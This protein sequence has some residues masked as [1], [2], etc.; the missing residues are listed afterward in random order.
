MKLDEREHNAMKSKSQDIT[1]Q[2]VPMEHDINLEKSLRLT[3]ADLRWSEKRYRQ[4][5]EDSKDGILIID[6]EQHVILEVNES[7]AQMLDYK[8]NQLLN[9]TILDICPDQLHEITAI[10][11]SVIN[12]NPV[13]NREL[14]CITKKDRTLQIRITASLVDYHARPAILL[15]MRDFTEFKELETRLIRSEKLLN[16]IV[17]NLPDII[18]RLDPQGKITFINDAVKRY[19][20]EPDQLL[21]KDIQELVHPDDRE[22]TARRIAERRTGDRHTKDLEVRLLVKDQAYIPFEVRSNSV[23]DG[24][25]V[26]LEV[27]GLYRDDQPNTEASFLGSQGVARDVTERKLALESIRES[28][29]RYRILSEATFE[30]IIHSN[31]GGVVDVNLALVDMLGYE[32]E[33]LLNKDAL[34]LIHPEDHEMVME[35]LSTENLDPYELRLIHKNGSVLDAE[36][37]PRSTKY[38]GQVVRLSAVRDITEQKR[39]AELERQ[40]AEKIAFLGKAAMEFV[41]VSTEDDIYS[42]IASK[43]RELAGEA[44][45][46]VATEFDISLHTYKVATIRGAENQLDK[47]RKLLGKDPLT[48]SGQLRN[49]PKVLEYGDGL[50]KVDGGIHEASNGVI[51]KR[52]AKG[53]EKLFQIT[54]IYLINFSAEDSIYGNLVILLR[55][56]TQ[57]VDTHLLEAFVRNASVALSRWQVQR[58]H[59]ES[60]ERYRLLVNNIPDVTWIS[61]W[62]GNTSFISP[63]VEQVY[64]FTPDE[65]ITTEQDLWFDRIHPDDLKSV[66]TALGDF[67]KGAERFDIE[68]RI[69][70]K[71]GSWIWIHD[72]AM[73]SYEAGGERYAYG[74]FS[75][76]TNRKQAEEERIRLQTAIEQSSEAIM[77]LDLENKAEY[78]NPA[79]ENMTGYHRDEV[80]GKYPYL[81]DSGLQEPEFYQHRNLSS[82][83]IWLKRSGKVRTGPA[84]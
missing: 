32:K 11:H 10:T 19:G 71:D 25:V 75:D 9:Q 52:A 20:Y 1:K 21:N 77:L 42:L 57:G 44:S 2:P 41:N 39:T 82:I 60:E 61:D 13:A 50:I 49:P 67:F 76:I 81:L 29:E 51:P 68:Y 43:I 37:R 4:I 62:K 7:L 30:G 18:Y 48:F 55:R 40:N 72:R 70:R 23:V 56:G 45:I 36:V 84:G 38:N 15:V 5:L 28:E 59:K 12:G 63:N 31:E 69:K 46:V 33:E 24:P 27:E 78:V 58:K 83:S 14:I 47:A 17:G 8:P 26:L 6:S 66:K 22:L 79:F 73:S 80:M 34:K 53:L 74:V 65:I 64:G 3:Q 54:D 16:S 35:R